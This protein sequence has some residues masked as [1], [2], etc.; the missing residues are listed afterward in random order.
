MNWSPSLSNPYFLPLY[1]VWP[2]STWI[3]PSTSGFPTLTKSSRGSIIFPSAASGIERT[4]STKRSNFPVL[5]T[6]SAVTLVGTSRTAT[7]VMAPTPIPV[8]FSKIGISSS[9]GLVKKGE[10]RTLSLSD[11]SP[12]L[13]K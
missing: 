6:I 7:S 11:L 1:Q 13:C 9:M 8:S 4:P 5:A 10:P 12:A 2:S 3:F